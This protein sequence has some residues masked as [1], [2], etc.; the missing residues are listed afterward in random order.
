MDR[1]Y[2]APTPIWAPESRRRISLP[3]SAPWLYAFAVALVLFVH[4][5]WQVT[6]I[7]EEVLDSRAVIDTLNETDGPPP[8]AQRLL[9]GDVIIRNDNADV[10]WVASAPSILVLGLNKQAG[11]EGPGKVGRVYGRTARTNALRLIEFGEQ[12]LVVSE[13]GNINGSAG[14]HCPHVTP[15]Y[16]VCNDMEPKSWPSPR[17]LDRLL[18]VADRGP[19]YEKFEG[20]QFGGRFIDREHILPT[21]INKSG[22]VV[23]IDPLGQFP[24]AIFI[25]TPVLLARKA[26]P[27][28]AG[29]IL[30]TLWT[31]RS[32]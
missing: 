27:I 26:A 17:E 25:A 29:V 6:Y 4:P 19:A 8:D 1:S 22:Q 12:G 11:I 28:V 2:V 9:F 5:A 32:G 10:A 15:V 23:F 7:F 16:R 13:G 14:W 18:A 21:Q 3:Q 31:C 24:N 20:F 30:F